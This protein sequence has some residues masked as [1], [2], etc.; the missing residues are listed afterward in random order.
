MAIQTLGADMFCR[1]TIPI[2]RGTE[3]GMTEMM[4]ALNYVGHILLLKA[5]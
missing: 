5:Y 2:F 1:S 4:W 3:D